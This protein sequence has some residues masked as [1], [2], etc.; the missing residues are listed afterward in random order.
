MYIQSYTCMYE[1]HL[2]IISIPQ[3]DLYIVMFAVSK[4]KSV[5]HSHK[6]R[7]KQKNNNYSCI[8]WPLDT[9]D[10]K[11]QNIAIQSP[12][13][14]NQHNTYTSWAWALRGPQSVFFSLVMLVI[15]ICSQLNSLHLLLRM[16]VFNNSQYSSY[17]LGMLE[18]LQNLNFDPA[19]PSPINELR[20][21][22]SLSVYHWRGRFK[23][24]P[25]TVIC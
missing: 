11:M 6:K 23:K 2:I 24:D 15:Y 5:S 12:N 10:I 17:H 1:F 18:T 22:I 4:L 14:I 3:L 20:L 16:T 9:A 8:I 7:Q 19:S 25:D 13:N 21:K